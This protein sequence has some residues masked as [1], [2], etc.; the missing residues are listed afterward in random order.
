MRN[1]S[2]DLIALDNQTLQKLSDNFGKQ[3]RPEYRV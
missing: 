3:D 2:R 1:K